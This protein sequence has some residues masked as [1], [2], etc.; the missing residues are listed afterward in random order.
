MKGAAIVLAAGQGKRMK[1]R[2]AKV[3]HPI[4][5][6]PM[7]AYVLDRVKGLKLEK[8]LVI[9]GH[10]AEAVSKVVFHRGMVPLLQD[11]PLGTGDAVRAA[12]TSLKGYRGPVLI[13]NGDTPLLRE[14]TL[15]RLLEVQRKGGGALSLLTMR[16]DA[17]GGYGRIVRGGDGTI[18]KIVEARDTSPDERTIQEVNTG[19]YVCEA[20]FLFEAI[21]RIQPENDQQEYY[22]TDIVGIAA[23]RGL[24]LIGLEADPEEV[25]GINSRADLAAVEA[26]VCNRINRRWMEA[27]VTLI[28]PTRI[29]IDDAVT[30]GMDSVLYPGVS[31][32]GACRIGEGVMIKD[33]S[34]I[35]DSAI[36]SG[37]TIGPFAHLRPGSILRKGAK[38][39]N[40]VE[41]KKSELGEGSKA[42]HL[43]YLGDVTVGRGV[44]IGAGAITCNYDGVKKDCTVIEDE[45]FIGS[46]SQL[47]APVTVGKGA[48][49]AAGTTVTQDV[50][51]DALAISRTQQE[52]KADW[53]K[54]RRAK[55]KK[56][57]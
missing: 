54:K 33:Y 2:L 18:E 52:N 14:A 49:I 32:S 46:D 11:P 48:V 41:M 1:S 21:D 17:P 15:L 29:R 3:L 7:L 50:P 38:V 56:D 10:Q 34:V 40:F 37:A 28:D 20:D 19:V 57:G 31:L 26:V 55:Q 51:P 22:L 44:N 24:R 6:K 36:E 39:G 42:N 53:A 4:A 8:S 5:G 43:S 12:K 30:I 13:L 23:Q 25:M 27:G 45:V 47:I 16:M 35:E 9:V